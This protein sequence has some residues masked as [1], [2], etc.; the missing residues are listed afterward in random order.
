MPYEAGKYAEIYTL[1]SQD[2]IIFLTEDLTKEVAS[3]LCGLLIYY[4]S[5]STTEDITIFIHTSGG[6][7]SALAGIYDIMR[8]IEAPISTIG[9][10]KIYSAGA[11]LLASGT[12][13]KRLMFK[14]AD[15][16]IHGL[17]ATYPQA[18]FSDQVDN[19]IYYNYLEAFNN[20]ILKI[21]AQHTGQTLAKISQDSKRDLYLDA[22]S[23]LKY[24]LIDKI[25]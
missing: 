10:G 9:M 18:Q 11:F 4:N 25:L 22:K 14:N 6:D 3:S 2:R 20:R 23:A 24:G 7:A 21:L 19:Q 15:V 12:K 8:L 17:Q 16:L 13:G 5:L 1:L